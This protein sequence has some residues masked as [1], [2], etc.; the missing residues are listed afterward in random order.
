M[1]ETGYVEVDDQ[2]KTPSMKG[3][4]TNLMQY[5]WFQTKPEILKDFNFAFMNA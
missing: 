4:D 3:L 2:T 1:K 5:Q